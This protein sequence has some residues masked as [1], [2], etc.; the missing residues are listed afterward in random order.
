[1]YTLFMPRLIS[2]KCIH[3]K[4]HNNCTLKLSPLINTNPK[5]EMNK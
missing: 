2:H 4:H 5:K 3:I 1:M